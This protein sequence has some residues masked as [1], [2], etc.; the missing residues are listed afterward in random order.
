MKPARLIYVAY[1]LCTIEMN[2]EFKQTQ[3]R[4]TAIAHPSVEPQKSVYGMALSC[5][6]LLPAEGVVCGEVTALLPTEP[7]L[8]SIIAELVVI[9][10][11][12]SCLIDADVS[13]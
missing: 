11:L 7:T 10:W 9:Y 13:N 2:G 8:W 6:P 4:M 1:G 12:E 3:L 5:M